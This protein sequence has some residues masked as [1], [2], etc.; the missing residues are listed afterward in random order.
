[1]FMNLQI[2]DRAFEKEFL[3]ATDHFYREESQLKMQE[4]NVCLIL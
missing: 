4:L 3:K 1:M 2:Y